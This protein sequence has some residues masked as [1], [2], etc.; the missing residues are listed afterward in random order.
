MAKASAKK[1]SI[2][3]Q[4][5]DLQEAQRRFSRKRGR[6]SKYDAV[7]DKAEKLTKGKALVVEGVSYAE[8]TAIRKRISDMLDGSWQVSATRTDAEQ[9][10]YDML[11]HREK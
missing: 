1:P 5:M 3:V 4:E 11:I 6:A 7:L 8:V 9:K 2:N 10:T